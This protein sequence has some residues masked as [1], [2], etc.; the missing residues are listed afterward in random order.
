MNPLHGASCHPAGQFAEAGDGRRHA[1]AA[2]RALGS[3]RR[4]CRCRRPRAPPAASTAPAP[5]ACSHHGST[6]RSWHSCPPSKPPPWSRSSTARSCRVRRRSA[7]CSSAAPPGAAPVCDL[8]GGCPTVARFLHFWCTGAHNLHSPQHGST[9]Q[10][11]TP[12]W[13][14]P[15]HSGGQ[16][17]PAPPP[18]PRRRQQQ[19]VAPHPPVGTP[20]T[21]ASPCC[22][23]QQQAGR[24]AAIGA[25]CLAAA[26]C[27]CSLLGR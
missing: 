22:G 9:L 20:L 13:R 14:R 24:R 5:A 18:R 15:P 8:Q 25:W 17:R 6:P 26:A 16:R 27:Q 10:M 3:L 4:C 11:T 2:A 1:A 12:G 23:E 7:A 21:L 19:R